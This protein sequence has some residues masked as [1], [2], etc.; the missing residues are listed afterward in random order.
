MRK[1]CLFIPAILSLAF[2][3]GKASPEAPAP[4]PG[5]DAPAVEP[6]PSGRSA[7]VTV[8]TYNIRCLKSEDT[9]YKAWSWRK[10]NVCALVEDEAFGVVGFQEVSEG[11]VK[12][13][14]DGLPAYDFHLVGR[15]DGVSKGESVG[16][17]WRKDAFRAV[18]KGRFFLSATP[19]VVS[20]PYPGWT[21]SDPGRNRVVAWAVLTHLESGVSFLAL[22]THLEV[23]KTDEVVIRQKS[24]ELIAAM[25]PSL[26]PSGLP[27]I[28]VGDMN[29]KPTE[30]SAAI[31]RK[32]FTD[33]YLAAEAAGVREGWRGSFNGHNYTP[34]DYLDTQGLRIDYIYIRGTVSVDRYRVVDTRYG[35]Y[36]PSDHCPVMTRLT[37][38]TQ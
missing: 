32:T 18:S 30:T 26:N 7:Q 28:L 15:E 34:D 17:A 20:S 33:T 23:G 29:S 27:V 1:S 31:F 37:L 2:S 11:M 25:L 9:G 35:G 38:Q 5:P 36:Y 21:S 4:D 3:C 13:L 24:A 12:D 22:S 8:A 16:I 14:A 10:G 19:D 6:Q